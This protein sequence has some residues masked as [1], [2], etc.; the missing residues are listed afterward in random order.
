MI[1]EPELHPPLERERAR[2]RLATVQAFLTEFAVHDWLVL[3]YLCILNVVALLAPPH[4]LR[5]RCQLEVLGLLLSLVLT[6]ILV[7][8]RILRD[9]WVPPLI[10]RLTIYGTVQLS[11][12]FFRH[13]LPVV[14]PR[15]LD[16][17]LYHFDQQLFGVEPAMYLDRL[18]SPITTEWFAFFYFGYFF[19][20][21]IHVIPILFLVRRHRVLGEFAMGMLTIFCIGHVLYMIV[22]GY[23]PYRA[24]SGEFR[25]AFPTGMWLDDVMSAVASGGAQKDIFP[26]LHTGAPT[27]ITLFCYRHRATLPFR[28]TWP[29]LAFFAINIIIATMFLRWHYVIDVVAGLLLAVLG[30]YVGAVVTDREL[31][32]RERLRLTTD[33]WPLFGERAR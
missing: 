17:R 31:T 10:Y 23:G 11:Y 29:I 4:P 13:Y 26:S 32:R 3:V 8:G 7:R 2:S 22:P 9:A 14:N 20:L 12:F 33:N 24:M 27:F 28:Y 6:L 21:A 19:V 15:S 1:A 25:H 16:L 18:V 30:R 5:M